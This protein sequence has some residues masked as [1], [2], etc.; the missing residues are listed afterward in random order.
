M[1]L[2]EFVA[3][4]V[5]CLLRE[6]YASRASILALRDRRLRALVHHARASTRL[7]GERLSWIDVDR[8]EPVNLA[9]IR[10]ITKDEIMSR[11]HDTVEHGVLTV[12]EL[13]RF[14]RDER[15]VGMLYKGRYMIA[16]TSGTTG[17]VG[18]FVTDA[19]AWASLNGALLARILRHRLIPREVLRFCFG[20]R[21]RMAMTIATGGHFITK[22]V[23]MFR[24]LLTRAVVD[25]RTFSVTSP[26]DHTIGRLNRFRPHYLHSYPTFLEALAHAKLEGVLDIEPEFISLGSEPFSE[27]ARSLVHA[28][29][30]GAEISETYGA[31]ECIVMANQCRE[32]RLHV[33]EDLCILEPVDRYGG[34]VPIGAPSAKVYVTNLLNRAQ[35]LLRYEL[36]DSVTML[37]GECPCGSPMAA[38]RVEGRSDDTFFFADAAGRYHAHPPIPF[39]A[40]F[41]NVTGLAQYQLIHEVQN[42]VRVRFVPKD[43]ADP[44][45]VA[46]RL[47]ER[48]SEYLARNHL[49]ECVHVEVEPVSRLEREPGGQK[50]RQVYSKV[51][52]PMAALE[53]L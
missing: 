51:P 6:R 16:T 36:Q 21:Y 3:S 27:N 14:T 49:H 53:A 10:P 44:R 38:I 4:A 31:T 12:P 37:G 9:Q 35:P 34:P 13:E 50:L 18:Y 11:F 1:A 42:H 39:E 19:P 41:L 17:S 22:L 28:A 23:S 5:S 45:A 32:G 8:P 2:V 43:G 26:I 29:F 40:L 46:R 47:I 24:P 33:N 7:W 15:H 20:R 52:Q 25:M 30:P 48:F